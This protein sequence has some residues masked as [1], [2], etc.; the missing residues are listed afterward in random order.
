MEGWG[1]SSAPTSEELDDDLDLISSAVGASV[2]GD[3][4][5]SLASGFA[6]ES[7]DLWSEF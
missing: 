3:S 7:S 2:A 6:D 5:D 1:E 4:H